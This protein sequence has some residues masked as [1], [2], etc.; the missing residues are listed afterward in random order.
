[1]TLPCFPTVQLR[2]GTG[3]SFGAALIL[4]DALEG[5][6]GTNILASST[7]EIVDI[8][9]LCDQISIRR[10]R[11]RIFEHYTS[12]SAVIRFRDSTG[13]W[14]P[15]N[16]S[17]LYY[18]Q[19]LPMRQVRITT[20]YNATEYAIFTGYISSWD[21]EWPQGTEYAWVTITA[22]D[23]FRLLSLSTVDTVTGASSGDLPGARVNQILDMVDWPATMR[24]ID[25]GSTELQNDPG[26]IRTTLTAL[27]TI[28]DTELGGLF[29]DSDGTLRFQSR[30]TISSLATQTAVNFA[31]DGTGIEYQAID[32]A[33][34][35]QELSNYVTIEREGGTPETAQ[36]ATSIADY[37]VRAMTRTGLLMRTNAAALAQANSIL[38]YRKTPR[39]RVNSITLDLSSDSPRVEPALDL[40]FGDPIYVTRTQSPGNAVT[41]RVTVQGV[42]H[43]IRPDRW[44]T[45]LFTREPLSTAF[46][47][48]SSQFGVLGTNTL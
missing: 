30:G 6:L 11:D 9:T 23:G 18:G 40:D 21:W 29:I 33:L 47:L 2:L 3:A 31:D 41:L 24:N 27:Q 22:D 28:E 16:P 13:D 26:G 34:D 36:D 46:I 14:N 44:I 17:G 10:G 15:D 43:D 35:D 45:R 39:M 48:G 19:I 42:D 32:V 20:T 7:A 12:G 38:A 8:S 25:T 1:V 37:F 5:I 4:G